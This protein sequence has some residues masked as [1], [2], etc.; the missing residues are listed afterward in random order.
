LYDF[1]MFWMGIS[2]VQYFKKK[3]REK[4]A[5]KMM[6]GM[7]VF[8]G[9]IALFLI[10]H[11]LFALGYL[12][13]PHLSAI[14]FLAAIN[15]CWHAF[16]DPAY[17]D[18]PYRCTLTILNGH[19]NVYNEDYHLEHHLRPHTHWLDY[20]GNFEKYQSEYKER[21]AIVLQDTQAF[22]VFFWIIL[23]RYDLIAQ[24]KIKYYGETEEEAME[25][26]QYLLSRKAVVHA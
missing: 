25:Q 9:V 5:R 12:I 6:G 16:A 4:P 23:K 14:I 7:A 15:Y 19:Y 18:D 13:L 17:P 1:A 26:I 21:N 20:P 22:E 11:P 8:Y 24:H 2:I 3:G 10:I